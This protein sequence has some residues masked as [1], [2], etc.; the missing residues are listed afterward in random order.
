MN[1][2]IHFQEY[3]LLLYYN[4]F[5]IFY[6][7]H[8]LLNIHDFYYN[9]YIQFVHF[10]LII[11]KILCLIKNNNNKYTNQ[12]LQWCLFELNIV[13]GISLL[14]AKHVSDIEF[15]VQYAFG[16]TL[17]DGNSLE[18]KIV[19]C[20]LFLFFFLSKLEVTVTTLRVQKR[21]LNFEVN[22][23]LISKVSNF[24]MCK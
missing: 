18:C 15:A 13:D 22:L 3:N 19:G 20:M 5:Y 1:L 2:L 21:T 16:I 7:F 10:F 24:E 12:Y 9:H 14:Q 11:K 4:I 17:H 8:Y 6:F 23:R